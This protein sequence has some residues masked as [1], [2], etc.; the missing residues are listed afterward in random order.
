LDKILEAVVRE[1][2]ISGFI[3]R[4]FE[5][6]ELMYMP[7]LGFLLTFKETDVAL[8]AIQSNPDYEFQFKNEEI[9]YIKYPRCREL[10]ER[11]GDIQSIICDFEASIARELSKKVLEHSSS[12]RKSFESIYALDW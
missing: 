11:F 4:E 2:I 12:I 6:A 10:D 7:Q 1:D 3:I 9:I 8:D 5:D